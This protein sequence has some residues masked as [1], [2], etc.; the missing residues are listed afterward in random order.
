MK[1]TSDHEERLPVVAESE[2]G[3]PLLPPGELR[4]RFEVLNG[5]RR[6][7]QAQISQNR[8]ELAE[9]EA[10][11]EIQPQVAARLETLCRNLFGEILDEVQRNLTFALR[12]VLGQHL[13]VT[14]TRE[15][16]RGKVSVTFSI[17]R[18]GQ[19]E[20]ILTGQGGSVCNVISVGLR[21]I[22]LSQLDEREHR[23]FLILDEQD[24]WL[25]PDLVPRL[26]SIISTI[27]RRM[28]FQILV[29]SHHDVHLFR[30]FADLIYRIMPERVPGE[31]VRV[32][33]LE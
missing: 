28:G 18:D 16:Q 29:I 1:R 4:R 5:N 33:L 21:L 11:L 17:E 9:Q 20:D 13:R 32:E 2:A 22:A 10:F 15:V 26:M 27:A 6:S 31:G 19:A 12:E 30:E 7:L 23:R 25:R 8:R 24:C 14:T 3:P